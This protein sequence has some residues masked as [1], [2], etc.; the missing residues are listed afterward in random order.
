MKLTLKPEVLSFFEEQRNIME[1]LTFKP[2]VLLFVGE[3]GTGKTSAALDYAL[4]LEKPAP[5]VVVLSND[6][7]QEKPFFF[8]RSG[9]RGWQGYSDQ[10]VVII[11]DFH[12]ASWCGTNNSMKEL[13]DICHQRPLLVEQQASPSTPL[14]AQVVI[15]VTNY[16]NLD[17][18]T[19]FT[20]KQNKHLEAFY[21]CITQVRWYYEGVGKF[22]EY[23]SYKQFLE[24]YSKE[25]E[26]ST[27]IK[28]RQ[29]L[30]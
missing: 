6:T 13:V 28:K 24:D 5:P 11:D 17:D 8:H 29:K 4:D 23:A 26:D 14:L 18:S 7:K 20:A 3:P 22:K 12:V 2:K 30:L 19:K 27:T 16:P 15:I 21:N 10:K 25:K 9:S 1:E